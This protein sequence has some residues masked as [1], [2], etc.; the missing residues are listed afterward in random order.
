[1]TYVNVIQHLVDGHMLMAIL[2][3]YKLILMKL[4]TYGFLGYPDF[5]CGWGCL[6][7][8]KSTP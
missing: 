7:T 3:R 5:A 6:A 8:E 2:F 4:M 1:M